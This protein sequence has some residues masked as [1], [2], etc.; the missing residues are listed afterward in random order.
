MIVN[1]IKKI[2]IKI[3][4]LEFDIKINSNY[5]EKNPEIKVKIQE[6]IDNFKTYVN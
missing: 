3:K 6:K 5:L 1:D 4:N 2:Q